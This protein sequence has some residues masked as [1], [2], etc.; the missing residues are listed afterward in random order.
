MTSTSK[1]SHKKQKILF[2]PPALHEQKLAAIASDAMEIPGAIVGCGAIPDS[3]ACYLANLGVTYHREFYLSEALTPASGGSRNAAASRNGILGTL[4]GKG[5]SCYPLNLDPPAAAPPA[6]ALLYIRETRLDLVREILESLQPL[7]ASGSATVVDGLGE[8]PRE[9][10]RLLE[11]LGI[12]TSEDHLWVEQ[13]SLAWWIRALPREAELGSEEPEAEPLPTA[14]PPSPDEFVVLSTPNLPRGKFASMCE[15]AG[16]RTTNDIT[17][18]FDIAIKWFGETFTPAGEILREMCAAT[19]VINSG[20]ED[21]SKTHVEAIHQE[22]FGYGLIVDP[23]SYVGDAVMKA[24]LNAQCRESVVSCP[25]AEA[26]PGFVYQR[27]IVTEPEP[28]EFE[29]YRVP[30][31]GAEI[32]CV[33]IKRRPVEQRF[34]RTAGYAELTSATEVF[35]AQEIDLLLEFCRRMG[36]EFGDLD[37]LRDRSDQRIHVIDA[38]PTPGGPGGPG[39]GYTAAQRKTLLETQLEALKR[40]FSQVIEEKGRATRAEGTQELNGSRPLPAASP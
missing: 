22:L 18:A 30:I 13:G 39:G 4:R 27:L 23:T 17:T 20:C 31:T 40:Y 14:D 6:V 37:V 7:L 8:D 11:T 36:L 28:E 26:E 16:Y 5:Y 25:V 10:R 19:H 21:I 35:D 2:S 38:N 34:D 29:E 24:N 9:L 1:T 3:R 12:E 32:P 15:M 33:V